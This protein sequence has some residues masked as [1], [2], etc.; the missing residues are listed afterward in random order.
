MPFTRRTFL[1]LVGGGL[2]YAFSFSCTGGDGELTAISIEGL[3]AGVDLHHEGYTEW[4]FIGRDG[5][6]TAH[7]GRTELGQGLKTVLSNIISQ[8]LDVPASKLTLILGDTESCPDDGPTT[9]SAA[10]RTVGWGYWVA[11]ARIREDLIRR[12]A[13]AL[14]LPGERL[15]YREGSIADAQNPSRRVAIGMLADGTVRVATINPEDAHDRMPAYVDKGTL[16]VNAEAIVTG[17]LTYA[18]DLFPG[19]CDYGDLLCPPYFRSLTRIET[20]DLDRARGTDGVHYASLTMGSACSV[21]DSY[22]AVHR[23]LDEMH[24]TWS[25]PD[26]PQA[27][28]IEREIRAGAE[29]KKTVEDLGDPGAALASS[30][31]VVAETYIT[32]YASQVPI[33][34]ETAVARIENGEVTVWASTQSPFKSRQGVSKRLEIPEGQ[35]RVIGMPVGGGFGVKDHPQAAIDAAVMASES[36]RT[37]KCVYSRERQF[38]GRGRYKEAVLIDIAS[39]LGP[40]GKLVARTIDIHQDEGFGTADTYDIPNVLTRLYETRMPVRHG[41]MRGT[42]FVQSGFAMES[43]TDMVAEAAGLDPVEF[44][45]RNVATPAFIPLLDACAEMIEYDPAQSREHHGT[46]FAICMHGGRQMGAAAAEVSVDPAT[47]R[48]H[49]LRLRGAFDIGTVININTLTANTKGAMI[50]GLGFAL[51]EDVRTDGHR[52]YVRYLDDYR[53]PRFSDV[54][55]IEIAFLNNAVKDNKPRGCGELP[56]V[57]TVSAICNAVYRAIGVRFYTLPLTPERVLAGLASAHQVRL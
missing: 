1:E 36:G 53:I 44:R 8:A 49:I 30:P 3:E 6:V 20:A 25:V 10:T 23:A 40:D 33:E 2:A 34:T 48:V 4:L 24:A 39:G 55:P 17:T 35:V 13:I 7:T 52:A 28:N 42:S 18:G 46:G 16:A 27:I 32:Q 29:L 12:A 38:A 43:H 14:D 47:G 50:W 26:R 19:E 45:R 54:P 5:S 9:G 51:F 41:V 31:L 15:V 37:V 21:G 57:P 11:C 56:V 22:P